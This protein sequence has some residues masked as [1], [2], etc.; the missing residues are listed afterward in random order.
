MLTT[1]LRKYRTIVPADPDEGLAYYTGS[2]NPWYM[3]TSAFAHGPRG[4]SLDIQICGLDSETGDYMA[5]C[6][7][8]LPDVV[9]VLTSQ[10]PG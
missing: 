4:L 3:L 9:K 5:R 8:Q 7:R 6:L 2:W 1:E 10:K